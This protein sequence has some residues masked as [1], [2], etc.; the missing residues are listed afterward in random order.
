MVSKNNRN[1]TTESKKN[2]IGD[3]SKRTGLPFLTKKDII[4]DHSKK[5]R[6]PFLTKKDINR[7]SGSSQGCIWLFILIPA[8]YTIILI[9]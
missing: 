4:G 9:S 3:H 1:I 8:I 5:T 7:G 2:K 6:L